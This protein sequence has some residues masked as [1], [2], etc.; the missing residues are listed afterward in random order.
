MFFLVPH[1]E[2]QANDTNRFNVVFIA[3]DDL[4]PELGCYGVDYVET[5]NID[6]LAAQGTLFQNHF[7]AVPTCG[8]SRYALLTGRDPSSSGV[9][10]GN[11]AL[12]QGSTALA[13]D[14]Q[15]GARSRCPSSSGA[16][17]TTPC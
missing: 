8:A 11:A 14:E 10:R 7:V 6:R 2:A 4:R 9:R 5:P 13:Q 16:A 15:P 1:A 17:G 3:I 12:Y